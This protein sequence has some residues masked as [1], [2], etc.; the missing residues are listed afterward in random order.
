MQLHERFV[1]GMCACLLDSDV[2]IDSFYSCSNLT[3]VWAGAD[4]EL[5]LKGALHM[6][7]IGNHENAKLLICFCLSINILFNFC[8]IRSTGHTVKSQL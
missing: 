8:I 5:D 1:C 2:G 6:P 3:H 4:P 7:F